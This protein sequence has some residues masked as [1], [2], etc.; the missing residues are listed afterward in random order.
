MGW[1]QEN[2]EPEGNEEDGT[3]EKVTMQM[4]E[5][6][7]DYAYEE[8][9][10]CQEQSYVLHEDHDN[11]ASYEEEPASYTEHGGN[12]DDEVV[13]NVWFDV[14]PQQEQPEDPEEWYAYVEQHE[15]HERYTPVE[16]QEG[17]ESY[18]N[19]Y[20]GEEPS[21]GYH[22]DEGGYGY[23]AEDPCYD[24]YGSNEAW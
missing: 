17:Q 13:Q 15:D 7:E 8:H 23:E 14:R 19:S 12:H 18:G 11:H 20:G 5:Y 24:D 16:Q 21:Y 3:E 4:A 10:A 1:H 2:P 9:E 6:A 22:D